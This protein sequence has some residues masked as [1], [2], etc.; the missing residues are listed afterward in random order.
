VEDKAK[1]KPRRR[2]LLPFMLCD[3][4]WDGATRLLAGTEQLL[5]NE[6]VK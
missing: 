2:L 6:H 5:E 4:N 1:E 3:K